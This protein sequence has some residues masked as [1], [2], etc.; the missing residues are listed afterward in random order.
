MGHTW[1]EGERGVSDG[2]DGVKQSDTQPAQEHG[3]RADTAE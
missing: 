1:Q 2:V 3:I